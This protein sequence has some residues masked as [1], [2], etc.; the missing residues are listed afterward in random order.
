MFSVVLHNIRSLYNVG[1]VFRTASGAGFDRVYLSGYTGTP[2][3]SRISKVALG[4]EAEIPFIHC[5][6][7]NQ[8]LDELEDHLIIAVEHSKKAQLYSEV[9]PMRDKPVTVIMG[10]EL[11]GIPAVLLERADVISEIPM[12]GKKES[13][14]VSCAF[15]VIAYDL[16]LKLNR[17][18]G[19]HL[20]KYKPQSSPHPGVL[21]TGPT[22]GEG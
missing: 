15:S 13:L 10:E 14:N 6:D 4:T 17:V 8:L 11:F 20:S 12:A 3:D 21:T 2:P 19:K 1:S 16:A 7:I 9:E 18:G 22:C 5:P